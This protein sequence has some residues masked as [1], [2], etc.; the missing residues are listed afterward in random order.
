MIDIAS[1]K[2][3]DRAPAP[4]DAG[5]NAARPDRIVLIGTVRAAGFSVNTI[6]Y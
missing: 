2:V 6:L 5:K 4:D 3:E 1:G